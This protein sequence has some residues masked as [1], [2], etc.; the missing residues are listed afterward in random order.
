MRDIKRMNELQGS[1]ADKEVY[2]LALLTGLVP[3]DLDDLDIADY[4]NVQKAFAEMQ[5]GK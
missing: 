4:A 1:D 3:E 2:M 5:K